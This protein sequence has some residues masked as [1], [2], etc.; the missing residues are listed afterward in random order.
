MLFSGGAI[1]IGRSFG[2]DDVHAVRVGYL[3]LTGLSVVAGY[4]AATLLFGSIEA[5]LL[6]AAAF[7]A[8]RAFAM[9]G[10]GGPNPK[11]PG[12]LLATLATALLVRR[13]WFW[14]G[15]AGSLAALTWQPLAVYVL[16]AFGAACAWSEPGRRLRAAFAVLVGAAIPA[17]GTAAYFVG[18][19]AWSELWES[20]VVIALT[21]TQRRAATLPERI[22]HIVSVVDRDFGAS[23]LLL[24]G[25]LAALGV[26]A[27]IRVR[28]GWRDRASL[29][30]DPIL[31]G[32]SVPLVALL[33][34]S[35]IDFQGYDDAYPLLPY[36]ALGV[37]GIGAAAS[38]RAWRGTA[39]RARNAIGLV[40]IGL[41]L[42]SLASYSAPRPADATLV[43][44]RRDAAEVDALLGDG[45]LYALGNP[46]LLVLTDRTNPSRFILLSAGVDRWVV[47][48]TP[49]G[50][51]GWL[52]RIEA[53]EADMIQ[54]D[55]WI[56]TSDYRDRI[57][58]QLLRSGYRQIRIGL[59][60]VL[61]TP[62]LD[63][64]ATGRQVGEL[65]R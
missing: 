57:R 42:A 46:A 60:E 22:G 30:R 26:L 55:A 49:G 29:I 15:A 4:L 8:F 63:E 12:V 2:A 23:G 10:L 56:T 50:L 21:G 27:A 62:G 65:L 61:V 59:L 37:A 58:R 64:R 5:G 44:Q 11:T 24:W 35:L 47:E 25:G 13:R 28:R 16:V 53:T 18:A 45:V 6:G 36:A 40:A 48:H 54:I 19:R 43:T 33:A 17:L 52:Q 20:A 31:L 9:D 34:F 7:A 1:A 38:A 51:D 41:V 14:A 39:G 32:V 3:V